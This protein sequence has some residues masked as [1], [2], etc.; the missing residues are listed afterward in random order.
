MKIHVKKVIECDIEKC[1]HT[2]PHFTLYGNEMSCGH[3]YF[4]DKGAYAG[5]IISHPECDSGFPKDC[6]LFR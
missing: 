1:Y 4:D 6:P 3:P 5:M 2:C